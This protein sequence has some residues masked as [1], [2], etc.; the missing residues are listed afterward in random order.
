M[1]TKFISFFCNT[2]IDCSCTRISSSCYY[3]YCDYYIWDIKVSNFF[4]KKIKVRLKIKPF[5]GRGGSFS[6]DSFDSFDSLTGDSS[7]GGGGGK[8]FTLVDVSCW[9]VVG[10]GSDSEELSFA[11]LF[12][13]SLARSALW[14]SN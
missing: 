8:E 9:E 1:K 14:E 13:S 12:A 11:N 5:G 3:C 4:L 7:G 6:F 10:E 2:W